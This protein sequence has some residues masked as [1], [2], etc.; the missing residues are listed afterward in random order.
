MQFYGL[1]MEDYAWRTTHV[2][3]I[4][5]R[6]VYVW[7]MLWSAW[8]SF[9]ELGV[10]RDTL[11]SSERVRGTGYW[12]RGCWTRGCWT[13]DSAILDAGRCTGCSGTG[14]WTGD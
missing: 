2:Y 5:T 8:E 13:L 4:P 1:R 12:T 6:T 11:E 9:G 14:Y 3:M 10:P 7:V